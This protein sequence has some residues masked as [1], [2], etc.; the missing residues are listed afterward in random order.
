MQKKIKNYNFP[1]LLITAISLFIFIS[2]W[3][4][5]FFDSD[6]ISKL[7]FNYD[8]DGRY[9]IPYIKYISDFNFNNSFD[10]EVNNLNILPIPIGSL[11][12]HSVFYK[13]FGI[14]GFVI[15]EIFII[16]IFLSIFFKIFELVVNKNHAVL[17]AVILISFPSIITLLD[18]D[19]ITL[20]NLSKNFFSFRPHR[21][22]FSNIFFYLGI[23]LLLKIFDSEKIL[24]KDMYIFSLIMGLNFSSFYYFFIILTIAFIMLVKIKIGIVK[25]VINYKK[26]IFRSIL[27]FLLTILPFIII[28]I[29][30]EKDNSNSAGLVDLNLKNKIII[31]KYYFKTFLN[32]KFLSLLFVLSIINF[33]LIKKKTRENVLIFHSYLL[34]IC[35]I[36]SPILF[37]VISP[38]SGLIYHFNNNIILVAFLNISFLLIIKI[39]GKIKKNN[40]LIFFSIIFVGI[41]I[42][43]NFYSNINYIKLKKN[44]IEIKE[45][46]KITKNIQKDFISNHK[47][48]NILTFDPNLMIWGI[49]NDVRY[50]K[51]LN[52]IW[53]PKNYE[54]I[55]YDLIQTFKFLKLDSNDFKIFL[56]NKFY[57]WRYFNKNI[58]E[59]F[60]YRYQAN[61]LTINDKQ[62][63]Y[64]KQIK[65]FILNSPPSLNQQVIIDENEKQRLLNKFDKLLLKNLQPADILVLNNKKDFLK[66]SKINEIDYCL[67]F[68]GEFYSLF[69][70]KKR[71]KCY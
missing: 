26:I 16:F 40:L 49:I 20:K 30:H 18:I 6:I 12:I 2:K 15:I 43:N 32:L 36:I 27:I 33:Y 70:L 61:I 38:K 67:K 21:P 57:G 8:G 19:F 4:L 52:Y 34:F 53:V 50:F 55:E 11:F 51:L 68:K 48:I 37:I 59:I 54:Q 45:F 58:V 46:I 62:Q 69:Y 29:I 25:F 56:D 41:I 31:L 60:G 42:L 13:M 47:E 64:T 71:E 7:I 3:Y 39:F 10:P 44:N 28:L 14:Y 5:L 65:N 17:F 24:K 22:I 35:A 66:N 63:V 9:W 1:I 23:Y